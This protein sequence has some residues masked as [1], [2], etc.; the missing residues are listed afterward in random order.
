MASRARKP[1]RALERSD[2]CPR[3]RP[4]RTASTPR[5]KQL[6]NCRCDA[7]MSRRF[8]FSLSRLLASTSLIAVAFAIHAAGEA[9][10]KI[11]HSLGLSLGMALYVSAGIGIGC[12]FRRSIEGAALGLAAFGV[13]WYWA[14]SHI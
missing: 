7:I 8:Q 10:L 6:G 14:V 2:G 13:A 12:L 3:R 11:A 9:G 5:T 1:T 4:F